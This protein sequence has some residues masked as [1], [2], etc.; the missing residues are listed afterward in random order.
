MTQPSTSIPGGRY[1]ARQAADGTWTILDV[2]IF[3]ELPKG[4]KG[5]PTDIGGEQLREC[6][7]R[8]LEKSEREAFLAP[9]H[10]YHHDGMG[11]A[12][13]AGFFLPRRV[14]PVLLDGQTM[15]A[16][17][18]DLVGVPEQVFRD[19][20]QARLPYRSVEIRTYEPLVFSSL[21]LLDTED[22]YFRFPLLTIGDRQ[23]LVAEQVQQFARGALRALAPVGAGAAALFRFT[24]EEGSMPDDEKKEKEGGGED[25]KFEATDLKGA[26]ETILAALKPLMDL[27][28]ALKGLAEG[29]G[30]EPEKKEEAAEI[31]ASAATPV[32]M[33]KGPSDAE[34]R[35]KA[36]EEFRRQSEAEKQTEALV[37]SAMAQLAGYHLTD[38]CKADIKAYAASGQEAVERFVKHIKREVSKDPAA[39]LEDARAAST[40]DAPEV[41][42]FA[43]HGPEALAEA[44]KLAQA[45]ARLQERGM[46]GTL[47][48]FLAV[49]MIPI[50]TLKGGR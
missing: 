16:I 41:A 43:A 47:E 12:L 2:P 36:L 44:R 40:A 25:K 29:K 48:Q 14:A 15:E 42:K 38:A 4:I 13:S 20:D 39:R 27:I 5:A 10:V 35:L 45:H 19:I 50:S 18:A 7:R 33:A 28:P 17:F 34:M 22:P 3:A 37:A 49:N 46:G 23:P 11:P 26:V 30:A 9:L 6:V 1:K 8:A 32:Q 31:A 24:T 21:A